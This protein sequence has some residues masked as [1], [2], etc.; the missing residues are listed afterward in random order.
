M[1]H[2]ARFGTIS[3]NLKNVKNTHG[4]MLLL[5]KLQ[6]LVRNY[7]KSNTPPCAFQVF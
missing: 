7:T 4:G 5:V 3:T 1:L 6:A 2:F